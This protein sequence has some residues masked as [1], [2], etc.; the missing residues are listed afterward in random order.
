MKSGIFVLLIKMTAIS[1]DKISSL[2][3][4]SGDVNADNL[5]QSTETWIYT[6]SAYLSVTAT[7]KATV[8]GYANGMWETDVAFATVVVTPAAVIPV[9]PPQ[10]NVIK[11][12]APLA[13]T[14][15]QGPVT[16]TYKVTN[17]GTVAL[18]SVSVTDDK[19]SN[20]KYIS[21]DAN[22]DNLLQSGETW[23]YTGSA[24][25]TDTTTNTATAKGSAN[26]MIAVDLAFTTVVVTPVSVVPV[27]PPLINVVKTASPTALLSGEGRVLYTYKVTNPGTVALSSVSVTDDKAGTLYYYAGDINDDRLLQP[28]ETWTYNGVMDLTATTTNTATAKGS[29]N[30]MVA[31]D[32]AFATVVVTSAAVETVYPP[33]INVVKTAVSS[34]LASGQ[35]SVAY[36]YKVTNPGTVALSNVSVTD[37]KVAA[38]TYVSGDINND[39]RLQSDE[40]WT[41]TGSAVLAVTTTNTA[42][43]MGIANGMTAVDIAVATVAVTQT[44]TGGQIPNTATPWYNI[45]FA[46]SVLTLIGAAGMKKG[47][48]KSSSN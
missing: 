9:V 19:V 11:T 4:V 48:I 16:Y 18:S 29:A 7:N 22:V 41:Y 8:V 12:A 36:T 13:L 33:L 26:G 30:G 34:V 32:V 14:L 1:D 31:T 47:W 38:V 2:T 35:K 23:T 45:L 21:G 28:T 25:L 27:V 44:A 3:Y 46:G 37:D 40:I 42:T 39:S 43:A 5:L 10:I 24:T 6:G 17:P 20:V 15:G